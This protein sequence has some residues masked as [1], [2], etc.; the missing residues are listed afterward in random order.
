MRGLR[1]ISARH[2][3]ART[4]GL[5]RLDLGAGRGEIAIESL[6]AFALP[7]KRLLMVRVFCPRGLCR[8]SARYHGAR[9]LDLQRVGLSA[10]RREFAVE[11][12]GPLTFPSER[13]LVVDDLR[14]GS[15][16]YISARYH[17][18][19]TLGRKRLELGS[20]RRESAV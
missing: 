16:G 18:A 17:R 12:L 2:H 10:S 3:R 6:G 1:R 19:R 14:L 4:L 9:T 5:Q 11:S 13:L 15:L 20:S 8:I 7:G